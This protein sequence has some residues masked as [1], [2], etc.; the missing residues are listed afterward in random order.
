MTYWMGNPRHPPVILAIDSILQWVCLRK[1][2]GR[3]VIN[4]HPAYEGEA[5]QK[6]REEIEKQKEESI[7]IGTKQQKDV[8]QHKQKNESEKLVQEIDDK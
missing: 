4:G 3:I 5:A 6:E 2:Q 7:F 1:I 8:E